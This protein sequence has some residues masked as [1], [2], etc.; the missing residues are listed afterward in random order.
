LQN[1]D[2]GQLSGSLCLRE[3]KGEVEQKATMS[4]AMYVSLRSAL[5]KGGKTLELSPMSQECQALIPK[6]SG[7]MGLS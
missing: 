3:G 6:H 7:W 5:Q 1:V 4:C 2:W